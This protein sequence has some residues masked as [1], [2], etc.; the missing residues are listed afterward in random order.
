MHL[1]SSSALIGFSP[2]YQSDDISFPPPL[3][4]SSLVPQREVRK[5]GGNVHGNSFCPAVHYVFYLS[6][7]T[8]RLSLLMGIK[9]A[10][11]PLKYLPTYFHHLPNNRTV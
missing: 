9:S 6:K 4:L 8:K 5:N 1:P 11:H 2:L 3:P 10:L 7:H